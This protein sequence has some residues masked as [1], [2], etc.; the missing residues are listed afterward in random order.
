MEI[1]GLIYETAMLQ[2]GHGCLDPWLIYARLVG[3]LIGFSVWKTTR[4]EYGRR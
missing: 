4:K 2:V 3:A 1:L